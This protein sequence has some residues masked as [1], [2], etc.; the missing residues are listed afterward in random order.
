MKIVAS[1]FKAEHIHIAEKILGKKLPLGAV[2]HHV[3]ENT[4]NN[5]PGNLVICPDRAYHNLLHARMRA[6]EACGNVEWQKCPYCKQYDDPKNMVEQ[7]RYG[8]RKNTT[9]TLIHVECKRSYMKNYLKSYH[10]GN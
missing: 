1:S 3:D 6:R 9:A 4:L 10:K 5:T 8:E 7:K 2:I